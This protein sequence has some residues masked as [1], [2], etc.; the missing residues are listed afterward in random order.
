MVMPAVTGQKLDIAESVLKRAGFD[1]D[2]EVSGGGTFGVINKSNWQV[3]SQSPAAGQA[4]TTAPHLTVDRSCSDTSASPPPS[5]VAPLS[6]SDNPTQASP[7]PSGSEG[8]GA[9]TQS[10]NPDFAALLAVGDPGDP[11]VE[12]FDTEYNGKTVEFEGNV[13]DIAS[14][15]SA[16]TLVDVLVYA[17]NYSETSSVGPN[18]QIQGVSIYNLP[19]GLSKGDNIHVT[20]QVGAYDSTTQILA[21][22][23]S[24]ITVSIRK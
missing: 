18:F 5:T 21:L 20:A 19:P 14:H 7:E 3:C 15:G 17:G 2:V 10:N 11:K 24:P 6:P 4:V 23:P 16:K 12:E 8:S 9:L 1:G 22:D 13:A